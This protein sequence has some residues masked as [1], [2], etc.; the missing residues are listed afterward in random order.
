MK[1]PECD[2]GKI[3]LYVTK[4]FTYDFN[5]D[6]SVK[7]IEVQDELSAL[8]QHL[9]RKG[10]SIKLNNVPEVQDINTEVKCN[11]CGTHYSWSR[12]G[13]EK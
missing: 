10:I 2:T 1:C 8:Q 7:G 12:G 13:G 3:R 4:I 11:K 5:K 6:G 9:N